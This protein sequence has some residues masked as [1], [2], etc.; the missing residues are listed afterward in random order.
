MIRNIVAVGVL[1]VLAVVAFLVFRETPDADKQKLD[2][3]IGP[4]PAG[5]LDRIEIT[6]HEGSGDSLREEKI[7]LER[8]G[9]GWRMKQPVDYAINPT[10]VE[11]MT[12]ALTGLDVVDAISE[13]PDKHHVLEVDDEL[14]I[15]VK[16]LGAGET[17]AHLVVGVN[18]NNMTYVRLPG[19]DTVYRVTGSHRPTFNK[20]AKNLRDKKVLDLDDDSVA[21]IEFHN[22]Q[23][24]LVLERRGEGEEAELVPVDTDT[25]IE[26]ENFDQRRARSI[27]R[28]LTGLSARDF[29]DGDPSESETGLGEDAARVV[30]QAEKDGESLEVT[31]R[32]GKEKDRK[33]YLTTSLSDQVFLVSKHMVERLVASADDFSRTDEEV[34]E[35]EE[36]RRK[37]EQARKAREAGQM[38]PGMG[39]QMPP[40]MGGKPGGQQIPPEVMKKIRKKM[41]EQDRQDR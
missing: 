36:R 5:E 29:A 31:V 21:R 37:A 13:N 10:S 19:E 16:A 11:R 9:E 1:V 38:P 6:R 33:R 22:E 24:E 18:R 26:I 30:F 23:G 8:E 7:V 27:A 39:G 15:E 3:L 4:V 35:E 28:T 2:E 34:A 41:E 40:G 17:L 12:E 32:I 14:G 20:S 25:E